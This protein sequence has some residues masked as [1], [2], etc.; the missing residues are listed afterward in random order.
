MRMCGYSFMLFFS[1][2]RFDETF[3]MVLPEGTDLA[4]TYLQFCVKD[5]GPVMGEGLLLGE[6]FLPLTDIVKE[7]GDISLKVSA[8]N[9]QSQGTTYYICT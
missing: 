8:I 6:A 3:D 9:Q 7:D 4:K 1:S 2:F 5:Q